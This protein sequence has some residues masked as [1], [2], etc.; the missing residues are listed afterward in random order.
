MNPVPTSVSLLDRL[1]LARPDVSDWHRLQGVYLPL[2]RRWL[3]RVPGLGDEAD[4]LA[5]DVFVVVVR[6]LRRFERRREGPFRARLR[7]VKV[8]QARSHCR[9]RRRRPAVGLDQAVGFLERLEAPNGEWDRDHDH[10]ASERLLAI[11][12]PD[13]QPTTGKHSGDSHW[14]GFRQR[15]WPRSWGS[16]R[17]PSSRPRR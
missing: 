2:I 6:E 12:Q 5:Q 9:R 8:N 13:F 7:Q 14:M 3:A 10:H 17:T 11:V 4:D 16:A 15:R 1:N